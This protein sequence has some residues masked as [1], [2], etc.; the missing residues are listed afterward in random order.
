MVHFGEFLKIWSLRSNRVTRQISF[1]RSKIGGKCQNSNIPM[2]H[3]GWFS[4]T[5]IVRLITYFTTYSALWD[6]IQPNFI[7]KV[8]RFFSWQ[9][10]IFSTV[11]P[12]LKPWMKPL[13]PICSDTRG[14]TGRVSVRKKAFCGCIR[15][16][17]GKPWMT[18]RICLTCVDDPGTFKALVHPRTWLSYWTREYYYYTGVPTRFRQALLPIAKNSWKFVYN[19]AKQCRSHFNLTRIFLTEKISKLYFRV[20]FH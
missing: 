4:N 11:S 12:G 7:F 10:R 1:N 20:D 9:I 19:L 17:S 16:V 18:C 15:Q 2:G 8:Q 3:F 14:Y 5:V 13:R 6:H